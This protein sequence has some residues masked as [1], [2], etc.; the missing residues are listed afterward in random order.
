MYGAFG[1]VVVETN[2]SA[3][4]RFKFTGRE[5][6]ATTGLYYYRARYYDP[7]LGR[8]TSQDP[9]GFG[10]GD[11]NLYR[12]GSNDPLRYTDPTGKLGWIEERL[13]SGHSIIKSFA[14]IGFVCGFVNGYL[15]AIFDK[16]LGVGNA[17]LF[18]FERGLWGAGIGMLLGAATAINPVL[19]AAAGMVLLAA[20]TGPMVYLRASWATGQLSAT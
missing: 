2:P 9:L 3:G 18:A 13:A 19:G 20:V 16:K 4:D 7:A 5:F 17:L 10:A 15:R 12:Y 6:D 8:F 1:N 14:V 11:A